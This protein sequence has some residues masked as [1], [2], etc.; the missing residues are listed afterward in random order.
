M[1]NSVRPFEYLETLSRC[2]GRYS[3]ELPE[4][5]AGDDQWS[6]I[7]FSLLNYPFVVSLRDITRIL[8]VPEVTPIPGVKPWAKGIANV[9]NQ[10]MPVVNLAEFTGDK[11][12]PAQTYDHQKI[13]TIER[14]ELS[15]ALIV[16]NVQG[17]LHF[18]GVRFNKDTPCQ[19]PESLKPFARGCYQQGKDYVVFSTEQLINN[20]N[21]LSAAVS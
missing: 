15:V 13:I 19:L 4:K 2:A 5:Q 18:P 20:K 10:L 16:D 21:F 6:G 3:S 12:G 9:H 11:N 1:T 17:V 7:G 14:R 8:P